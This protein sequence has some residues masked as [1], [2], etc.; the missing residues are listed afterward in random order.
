[1]ITQKEI[2]S[3][4]AF[5]YEVFEVTGHK[6]GT[7]C[8]DYKGSVRGIHRICPAYIAHKGEKKAWE[9]VLKFH[10]KNVVGKLTT[11][12]VSRKIVELL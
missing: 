9:E 5:G 8:F 4:K 1:M 3:L 2:K 12:I 6:N 10:N 7:H 11:K